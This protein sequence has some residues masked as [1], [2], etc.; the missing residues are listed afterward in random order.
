MVRVHPLAYP[1]ENFE[2]LPDLILG[3]LLVDLHRHHH[4]KFREVDGSGSVLV[5]FIDH[6]LRYDRNKNVFFFFGRQ[7]FGKNENDALHKVIFGT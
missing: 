5:H 4:E 3:I 7:H 2:R 6:V 1:V